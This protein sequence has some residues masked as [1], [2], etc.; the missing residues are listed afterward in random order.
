MAPE[1][2]SKWPNCVWAALEPL[3]VATRVQMLGSPQLGV[4][5]PTGHPAAH[6][7]GRCSLGKKDIY[8]AVARPGLAT[9]GTCPLPRPLALQ[10]GFFNFGPV[11]VLSLSC[12]PA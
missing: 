6:S 9:Q 10:I 7:P 11:S 12:T 5:L 1:S 2:V 4:R 3:P 8:P